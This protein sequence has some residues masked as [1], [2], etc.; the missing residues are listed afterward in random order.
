MIPAYS[1]QANGR[2]ERLFRTFQDRVITALRLAG[3]TTREAAHRFLQRYLPRDHR[4]FSCAPRS[5]ED[6]HHPTPAPRR[7]QRILALH[8]PRTLRQDHTLQ[9]EGRWD[10]LTEPWRT[11]RPTQLTVIETVEGHR[12]LCHEGQVLGAR[13]ITPAPRAQPTRWSAP[14]RHRAVVLPRADHPWRQFERV[15]RLTALNNRTVLSWHN[16]DISTLA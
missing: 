2:V 10:L 8:T 3:T 4:R 16:P 7:L 12:F 1:P 5:T 11:R 15:Q 9:Y 6:L 14:S 13:E